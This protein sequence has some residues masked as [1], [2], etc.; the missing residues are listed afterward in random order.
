MTNHLVDLKQ[1]QLS[2]NEQFIQK[3]N[4]NKRESRL[5]SDFLTGLTCTL[6]HQGK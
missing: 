4:K 1:K 5:K 3:E 6:L 2:N